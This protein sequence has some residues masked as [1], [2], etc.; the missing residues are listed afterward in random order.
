MP[1]PHYVD[2][3]ALIANRLEQALA[4]Q[5]ASTP[6]Y[7]GS[8]PLHHVE[9]AQSDRQARVHTFVSSVVFRDDNGRRLC[10]CGLVID[11]GQ[12][13]ESARGHRAFDTGFPVGVTLQWIHTP[14][15]SWAPGFV[16]STCGAT[17]RCRTFGDA[18]RTARTHTCT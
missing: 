14:P 8:R 5:A 11:K 16:C 3:D 4:R 9:R 12:D 1:P 6:G 7:F 13:L 15:N 10:T 17:A 18:E 2:V